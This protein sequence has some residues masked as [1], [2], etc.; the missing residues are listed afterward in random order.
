MRPEEE[1]MDITF[2]QGLPVF[3]LLS[4]MLEMDPTHG[5]SYARQALCHCAACSTAL[6]IFRVKDG[7][8]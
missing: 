4:A 7:G 3:L 8:T 5:L 6:E 2:V 1:G